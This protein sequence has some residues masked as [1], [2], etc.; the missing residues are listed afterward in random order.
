MGKKNQARKEAKELE[1]QKLA[2]SQEGFTKMYFKDEKV[3][4][5][6][7]LYPAKQISEVPN[8]MV[9]RWLKRGGVL[10]SSLEE[11]EVIETPEQSEETD[12]TGTEGTG[13]EDLEPSTETDEDL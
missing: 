11:V 13:G 7:F 6:E 2:K 3:Y 5:G 9:D 8:A 12:Q 1:K 10:A 4:N